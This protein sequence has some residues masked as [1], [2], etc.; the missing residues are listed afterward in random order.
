MFSLWITRFK[1]ADNYSIREGSSF[2]VFSEVDATNH[3]RSSLSG[4]LPS[5]D[6]IINYFN[7]A[8]NTI[9]GSFEYSAISNNN[10]FED[11]IFL[12]NLISKIKLG[13]FLLV[14]SSIFN[15]ASKDINNVFKAAISLFFSALSS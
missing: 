1:G 14:V 2:A 3:L 13:Y 4:G 7:T 8:A 5:G 12:G 10:D 6:E 9:S 15:L 11:D